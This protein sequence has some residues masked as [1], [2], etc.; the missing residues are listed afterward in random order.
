MFTLLSK[1]TLFGYALNRFATL[2]LISFNFPVILLVV[3]ETLYYCKA[4]CWDFWTASFDYM[5]T[6]LERIFGETYSLLNPFNGGWAKCGVGTE[7]CDDVISLF[8]F[9]VSPIFVGGAGVDLYFLLSSL[10]A[11]L[12]SCILSKR[13]PFLIALISEASLISSSE[14][15]L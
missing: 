6:S 15:F 1:V 5:I 2:L 10:V 9:S 14:Y 8:L 13:S 4:A 3:A 12:S 7:V 11:L